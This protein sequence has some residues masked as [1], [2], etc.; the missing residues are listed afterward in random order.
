MQWH[1]Q[2]NGNLTPFDVVPGSGRQSWWE[3]EKKHLHKTEVRSRVKSG[4]DGCGYCSGR[5][6]SEQINLEVTYPEIAREWHPIKN[7]DL[8]PIDVP[9]RSGKSAWW[10][11]KDCGHEWKTRVIHRTHSKSNCKLC[12]YKKT[13]LLVAQKRLERYGSLASKR[14][15]AHLMWDEQ[16]NGDVTVYDVGPNSKKVV[17]WRCPKG[18]SFTD[19]VSKMGQRRNSL[20]CRLCNKVFLPNEFS[21]QGI[22]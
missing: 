21:D 8:K 20:Y 15:L 10:R 18:H 17:W 1:D 9:I 7:L 4:T 16:R 19:P 5:L 13:A 14:P 11:C 2:L 3:C 12:A 6:A 22:D